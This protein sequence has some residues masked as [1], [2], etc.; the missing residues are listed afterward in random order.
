MKKHFIALACTAILIS[1]KN[2]NTKEVAIEETPE[3]SIQVAQNSGLDQWNEVKQVAFTFN[4][5]RGGEIMVSRNWQWNPQ[6]DQVTLTSNTDTITY[7]RSQ[8][9]DSLALS[10]DRAFVNDVY[11]LVPQFKLAWDQGKEITYPESADSKMIKVQYTGD[12]GYTPGDRYDMIIDDQMNI[13]KWMY[14]PKGATKPAMT[15]SFADYVKYNGIKI[16]TNHRTPDGSLNIYFTD[17]T[18]TKS[19]S[20]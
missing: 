13:N 4:V 20:L 17:I 1:C 8:Q 9:L 14:Y 19:Q 16:A 2:E 12:D 7:N 3:L 6:S 10:A 18:I 11:W 5:E 15:T